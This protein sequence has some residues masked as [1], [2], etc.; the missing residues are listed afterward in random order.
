MVKKGA[1]VAGDVIKKGLSGARFDEKAISGEWAQIWLSMELARLDENWADIVKE[2]VASKSMPS[3]CSCSGGAVTITVN[4]SGQSVLSSVRFRKNR[5]E[6]N[7]SAFLGFPIRLE[8]KA[9]P[10][11]KR[12]SAKEAAPAYMRRAPVVVTDDE[13]GKAAEFFKGND[14]SG[15]LASNLAKIKL[16]LEK[17]AQRR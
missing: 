1:V 11:V 17:I 8:L 4:V 14:I 5:L 3:A 2:P 13:I 16:R 12:S 6:K 7:I 10:V 15:E 9:G